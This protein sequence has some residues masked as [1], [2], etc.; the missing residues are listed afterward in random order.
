MMLSIST[1]VFAQK[2]DEKKDEK[3]NLAVQAMQPGLDDSAFGDHVH[4]FGYDHLQAAPTSLPDVARRDDD[5][6][7]ANL[8]EEVKSLDDLDRDFLWLKA[9]RLELKALV[10]A[11]PQIKKEK[12]EELKKLVVKQ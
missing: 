5:F 9:K 4:K 12:L 3:P 11:Y 10:A 2:A 7:K 6:V 1:S 8:T